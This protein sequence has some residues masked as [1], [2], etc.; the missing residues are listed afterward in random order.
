MTTPRRTLV[1]GAGGFIGG[2]VVEAM[3]ESG[4]REPVAGIRRWASAARIGRYALDPVHCDV[5]DRSSVERAL[6]GV[7][8]VVHCAVGKPEVTVQGTRNVLESALAAGV[9]RVVHVSTIDVY[10]RGEGDFAET[11]AFERTGR[12]YGDS[13]IEAEEICQELVEAGLEV[14]IVRPT[15]V[16]GPFSPLWTVEP[17]ERLWGGTWLLP[18][19]ACAG[20]CNLVYVD[21]LVRA[22]FLALD[23]PGVAGRAYNVN[24]PDRPT[25]Q[26]YIEALNAALG[27]PPLE[28]PAPVSSRTRTALVQPFR[29]L[30]KK[31]YFTF[32]DRILALYKSSR[33]ARRAMKGLQGALAR[34]P[35]PAEYELYGRRA[36]FPSD[37][38]RSELGYEPDTPMQTGVAL[39]VQ[40]LLHEG[41]VRHGA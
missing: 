40:W 5:M 14:T 10:G 7:E 12:P 20:T 2:R 9:R 26:E 29:T 17:A 28:P 8:S 11:A 19:E 4:D 35:S 41:V 3:M 36:W 34:V 16:Y 15:I 30:V 1:T 38:A 32:E 13:K 23:T 24:G 33:W 18:R 6:D 37:R 31:V 39:S 21:D 27:L 25:W 22:I